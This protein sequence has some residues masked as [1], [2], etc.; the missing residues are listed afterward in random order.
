MEPK[1]LKLLHEILAVAEVTPSEH[2]D[3]KIHLTMTTS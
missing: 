2:V 3:K 1:K